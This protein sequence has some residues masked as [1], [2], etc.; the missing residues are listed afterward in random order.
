MPGG[1]V[2]YTAF[3]K[4][5]SVVT[6]H[7]AA[8]MT[9]VQRHLIQMSLLCDGTYCIRG[10]LCPFGPEQRVDSNSQFRGTSG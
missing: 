1:I 7:G 3:E 10:A 6:V 4:T 2:P 9:A 8:G 5:K